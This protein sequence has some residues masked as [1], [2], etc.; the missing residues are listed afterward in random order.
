MSY[1]ATQRLCTPQSPATRLF[2]SLPLSASNVPGILD[3]DFQEGASQFDMDFQN[4][5][6]SVAPCLS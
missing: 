2:L 6:N 1:A 3:E 4:V 5:L